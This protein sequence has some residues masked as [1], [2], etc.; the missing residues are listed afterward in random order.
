M[1]SDGSES[2]VLKVRQGQTRAC[3]ESACDLSTRCAQIADFGLSAAFAIAAGSD[4]DEKARNKKE[5]V[6]LLLEGLSGEALRIAMEMGTTEITKVDGVP[7]L[8]AKIEES[9]FLNKVEDSERL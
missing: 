1:L 2:A 9:Y 5:Y 4:D 3:E 8:C 7:K 6:A